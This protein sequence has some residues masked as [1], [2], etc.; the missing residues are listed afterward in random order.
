MNTQDWTPLGWTGW[1]SYNA[2][3]HTIKKKEEEEE[4]KEK[5]F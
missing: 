4:E 2:H 1:I 5:G 3:T